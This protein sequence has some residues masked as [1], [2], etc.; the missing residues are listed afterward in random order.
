MLEIEVDIESDTPDNSLTLLEGKLL[1]PK[2]TKENLTTQPSSAEKQTIDADV[3]MQLLA[4]HIASLQMH[5]PLDHFTTHGPLKLLSEQQKDHGFERV[6]NWFE[7]GRPT[8]S[9]YLSAYYTENFLTTRGLTSPNNTVPKQLQQEVLYRIYNSPWGGHK[10]IIF[11]FR[12]R[13]YFPN[14][15]ETLTECIQN[16]LTC[17]RAIQQQHRSNH[18]SNHCPQSRTSQ[19]M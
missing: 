18:L 19:Q 10:G 2:I 15:T 12:K 16:C 7:R 9:Q 5:N 3:L 13:F 11:E 1:L 6:I 4:N 17:C 8:S 14:F